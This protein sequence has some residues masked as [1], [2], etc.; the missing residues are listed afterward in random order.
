MV[1]KFTNILTTNNIVMGHL[2]GSY[3][4]M[5]VLVYTIF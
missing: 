1:T 4:M 5:G 2:F 3:E